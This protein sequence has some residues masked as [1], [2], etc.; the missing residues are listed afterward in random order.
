MTTAPGWTPS[1]Y[2][3]ISSTGWLDTT[4]DDLHVTLDGIHARADHNI[5]EGV[6]WIF[7]RRGFSGWWG[8][9]SDPEVTDHPSGHGTI[10]GPP[11]LGARTIALPGWVRSARDEDSAALMR[12]LDRLGGLTNALLVV[13]ETS[14]GLTREADVRTAKMSVV[15]VA[16][17]LAQVALT[18]VAD[19][20]LR[21]GSGATALPNGATSLVNRGNE[22]A[23]PLLDIVGPHSAL[24]IAHPGGTWTLPAL[25]S[26]VVRTVDLR[27][28]AVY[29][30][31]GA[32]VFGSGEGSGPLPRVPAGGASWMVSGIGSGSIR[33][34][35]TEAWS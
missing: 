14:R 25:G 21:Y 9:T 31:A 24:S 20:P 22:T 10:P 1:G 12:A 2:P 23:W 15:Q 7:V 35:R 18:L 26:A 27:E 6:D 16:P 32:H 8:K 4:R 34:R 30:G 5:P 33:A 28:G 17:W 11:R 3:S 19:D 29:D 13:A